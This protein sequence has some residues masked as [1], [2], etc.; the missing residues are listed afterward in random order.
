MPKKQETASGCLPSLP[1]VAVTL[2]E[3]TRIPGK[4]NFSVEEEIA[5]LRE[6]NRELETENAFLK[7]RETAFVHD[8][9][10]T[11]NVVIDALR[12]VQPGREADHFVKESGQRINAASAD[13]KLFIINAR[14]KAAAAMIRESPAPTIAG[15]GEERFTYTLRTKTENRALALVDHLKRTGKTVLKMP[16]ARAVLETHESRR[17]DRKIVWRAMKVAQG[18]LRATK[19]TVWG[20]CRLIVSPTAIGGGGA[21]D[22]VPRPRRDRTPWGG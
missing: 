6:R 9:V 19:D 13:D 2:Q 5:F 18:L 14:I 7:E 12:T 8:G 16:E 11:L 3:D 15:E 17:L 22:T 20:V 10:E 4:I 21:E 1:E